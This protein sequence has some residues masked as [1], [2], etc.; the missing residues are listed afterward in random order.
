MWIEISIVFNLYLWKVSP[1][2]R[3]VWIEISRIQSALSPLT[4]TTHTGGVDWNQTMPWSEFV[5]LVTTHTG[6]VDWNY[7]YIIQKEFAWY[8][9]THT[10]GVDWNRRI[11]QTETHWNKSPPTRVVWIEI[12]ML[13]GQEN[14]KESPPTRVVWIEILRFNKVSLT[15]MRH[16]P[17]GWC[18]LKLKV[19]CCLRNYSHV[20][21]HTGGVDWNKNKLLTL[22]LIQ[23]SP[24]TR[25][26]WIE[27]RLLK[28]N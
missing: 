15:I 27:I 20:T 3:V 21:T 14:A 18:G 23:L 19:F 1:P 25:V 12:I 6:G 9:T 8:V 13:I 26:V 17:H 5:S 11:M 7:Y 4:V 24:P 22:L 28:N 2:T 16:H 10:G